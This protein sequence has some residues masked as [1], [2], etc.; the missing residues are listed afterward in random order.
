MGFFGDSGPSPA[1]KGMEY[2]NQI[3][4][5]LQ[6]NY[7]PYL[8]AGRNPAETMQGWMSQYNESP[9]T[10]QRNERAMRAAQGSAAAAGMLG[11]PSDQQNQAN[12]SASLSDQGMKD[13]LS[14]MFRLHEGGLGAT[15][16]F[17]GDMGNVMGQQGQLAYQDQ[18]QK[19]ADQSAFKNAI[20]QLIGMG[21]GAVI[22][23]MAGGPSGAV[24]GASIGSSVGSA[25]NGTSGENDMYKASEGMPTSWKWMK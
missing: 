19:S 3:P 23:G 21:G 5:M 6:Q 22:G 9:Y 1:S 12:L 8:Q 24:K 4:P 16:S 18:K 25:I 17:T 20:M 10:A 15:Q 14:N 7:N 2:I 13:W 11:T